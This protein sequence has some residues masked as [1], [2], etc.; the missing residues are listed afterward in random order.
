M[1][2]IAYVLIAATALLLVA[3]GVAALRSR[4]MA[5]AVLGAAIACGMAAAGVAYSALDREVPKAAYAAVRQAAAEDAE[6]DAI[7]QWILEDGVITPS[8]YGQV[9]ETYRD[10]TGKD[11]NALIKGKAT[12]KAR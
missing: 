1:T 12:E 8:E 9:A 3:A 7:A 4:M 2:T 10:R 5:F 6:V 11:M